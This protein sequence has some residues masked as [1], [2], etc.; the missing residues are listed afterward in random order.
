[1][2]TDRL[3]I[4]WNKHKQDA[5]DY[6][7]NNNPDRLLI[8]SELPIPIERTGYFAMLPENLDLE[9]HIRR[10]PLTDYKFVDWYG[11]IKAININGTVSAK[12]DIERMIYLLGLLISTPS[13]EKDS[14]DESG[15]VSIFSKRIRNHFKEYLS[16]LDYLIQTGIVVCDRQYIVGEKPRKYKYADEY[17]NTQLR[18]YYY[19]AFQEGYIQ[20]KPI[21]EEVFN[22]EIGDYERNILLDKPHLNY[23]YYQQNLS[24]DAQIAEKYALEILNEKLS[25]GYQHW[26]ESKTWD[27]IKKCYKK[28]NPK[29]QYDA[30][31]QKVNELKIQHYKAKIDTNVH[32]LNSV[33]TNMQKEFRNFLTYDG[34]QL[35]S[36]DVK[37]SQ[38]YLICLILNKEFWNESST[39]PI[40][41][42]NLPDNIQRKF[43]A[44]IPVLSNVR[45][46]FESINETDFKSYINYVSGGQ[47]Y[48]EIVKKAL[49]INKNSK[50]TRK[51]AKVSLLTLFY[52]PNRKVAN[53]THSPR[54]YIVEKV[55]SQMFPKIA[56]LFS[57]IKEEFTNTNTKDQHSRF[58]C[59]LQSIESEIILNRCCQKI[60]EEG[61]QQIPIFT[62]HDSIV[63]TIE[64]QDYVKRTMEKI[65]T[66]C[67]GIKPTLAMEAW[68]ISNLYN[69]KCLP[70][71]MNNN[72][73]YLL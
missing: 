38:P 62:I 47:M 53:N 66:E 59:L 67:I 18:T 5:I 14:I 25:L 19:K 71:V 11:H 72:P 60:W 16:Y 7:K 54:T 13:D 22:K 46:F 41:I 6:V 21:E 49:I 63:T 36:I 26:D 9:A 39:L 1:M 50:I 33:V 30:I 8:V 17:N 44:S 51:K 24:V 3:D 34:Q 20:V 31:I 45:S 48:E 57:L 61:N 56:L 70:T 58:A 27:K 10:Y 15:Y 29:T 43:N 4:I 42:N 68:H 55:F 37:N 12:F 73:M 32:R 40:N 65:M 2:T 52:S 28:K 69:I 35:V 64:H 23:W